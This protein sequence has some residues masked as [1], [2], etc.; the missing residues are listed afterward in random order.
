MRRRDLLKT[1]P[2]LTTPALA[3]GVRPLRFIP[4]ANL[5]VLDPVWTTAIIGYIHAYMVYDTLY[6][7]DDKNQLQPQMCAGH[8]V[9]ADGL[10]WTFT[11]RDGL[12]FHD[13][14][15]VLARDCAAS[16]RRWAARDTFGQQMS[17]VTEEISALDDRRFQI[18]L[19]KP[20]RMMLYGLGARQCFVMPERV[21]RTSP[22]EQIKETIGSGPFRFVANEWV[23]GVRAVY[24]KYDGYVPRQE[25]P[26]YYAG[27]KV[28]NFERVE[29]LIQP[30]PATAAAA[31]RKAEADWL[32]QPLIDLCPM[33]RKSPGV[34]V[35][36][37]DP[38]GYMYFLALNHLQPPFNNPA[39]RR[40]L[41]H[42]V[43]QKSFIDSVV[44]D[45]EELGSTPHGYFTPSMPM[46]NRAGLEILTG[47]RD[48]ALAKKL[49][50]EAGYKGEVTIIMAPS[51]N[52]AQG[53]LSQVA[54]ELFQTV[55]LNVDYQI[56]DWGSLVARRTNQ[57]PPDKGGWAAFASIASGFTAS[58][59]G[60]YQPIRGNG[61][62]GWFGWPTDEKLEALRE[63]WFD[64]PTLDAQ[65]ELAAQIQAQA[66][67]LVPVIPL[68]QIFQPAAFRSDIKDVVT[69]S[70]PVFWGV[71]RA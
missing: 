54:R 45:Q 70:F 23:S 64:A 49:I 58:G 66:L 32:E 44:G 2:L 42:A 36:V 59:P 38:N 37:V 9:S 61:T 19:K 24:T 31:L 11:L 28:V 30:D 55:G 40:A 39:I 57:G 12:M 16:V 14:E 60:S 22:T 67:Q 46:A 62:K 35:K 21:A 17:R 27:G 10:S 56:M 69:S 6:G 15:K 5:S 7:I 71:R 47:K 41:L 68:G 13:N 50:A 29:W 18:R 3:Q 53:Q 8:E 26:I 25:K 52:P 1:V 63:A 48:P 51:D 4:H 20:F 34:N 65:K 43:D 33:L